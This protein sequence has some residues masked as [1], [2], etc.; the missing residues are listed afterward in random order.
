L[1]GA[2]FE[3]VLKSNDA[4]RPVD[5]PVADHRGGVVRERAD[6]GDLRV[7][8]AKRENRR[9]A[10]RL[11]LKQDEGLLSGLAYER[12]VGID[13]GSDFF[14]RCVGMLEES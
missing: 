1:L 5:A 12:A 4:G 7:S 10:S 6:K 9:I 13:G 14:A 3:R 8:S 11:V 2:E